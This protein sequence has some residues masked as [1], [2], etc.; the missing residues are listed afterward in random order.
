MLE[1]KWSMYGIGHRGTEAEVEAAAKFVRE[2]AEVRIVENVIDPN[3][4]YFV[5]LAES[6]PDD[7]QWDD[8][9][10]PEI[11]EKGK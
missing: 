8:I 11:V 1:V 9:I 2:K 7:G 10:A 6:L 3:Q 5:G 4:D